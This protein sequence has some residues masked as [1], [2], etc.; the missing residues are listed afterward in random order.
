MEKVKQGLSL[1]PVFVLDKTCD[2]WSHPCN[3]ALIEAL[4]NEQGLLPG[5]QGVVRP[6][7]WPDLEST[8]DEV[9]QS[10][11]TALSAATST[12]VNTSWWTGQTEPDGSAPSGSSVQSACFNE[13][14]EAGRATKTHVYPLRVCVHACMYV[15]VHV[16]DQCWV[17]VANCFLLTLVCM[18][19]Q[20]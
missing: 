14:P 3:K 20:P 8:P 1:F 4:I 12:S 11:R 5:K 13:D 2:S 10:L 9:S 17:P 15:C 7:K 18:S 6:A 19:V 16:V